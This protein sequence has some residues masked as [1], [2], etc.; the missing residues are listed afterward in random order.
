MSAPTLTTGGALSAPVAPTAHR[1]PGT[2]RHSLLLAQ[3]SL[4]KTFRTPEALIDVT[5]QPAIFLVLFTYVFGGAI[6]NGSQ[7]DY[8]QFL[9]PGILAQ[10]IALGGVAIGVNLNEDVSKG[11]FDR[12]R[13]LPIARSTPLIGAVLADVV[14][15][16][17]VFVTTIAIGYLLGFRASGSALQVLA[18]GGIAVAFALCLSWASVFIGMVARTPGAV[19][20]IMMLVLFP[21]SFASSVFTNPDT[22]PGWLQTFSQNNPLTHLVGVERSLLL[23]DPMSDHLW[24]TGLWMAG[25]VA[26]FMPLALRAYGKK[27]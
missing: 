20:G 5:I 24:Q 17:L 14:R 26:V 18:A 22:M 6:A 8:L 1:I 15:Y 19:Q 21:L 13:S 9:L 27:V 12:F 7:H 16:A 25:L 10:T 23:G 4:V 2:I 3:R 11:V